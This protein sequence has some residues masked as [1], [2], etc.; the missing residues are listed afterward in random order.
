MV[1]RHP[2]ASGRGVG[3]YHEVGTVQGPQSGQRWSVV[4]MPIMLRDDEQ[5]TLI[6]ADYA[7]AEQ[8]TLRVILWP[9]CDADRTI[10]RFDLGLT[11][12]L[13]LHPDRH[14][15]PRLRAPWPDVYAAVERGLRHAFATPLTESE[16]V[17]GRERSFAFTVHERRPAVVVARSA[18]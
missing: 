6:G 14:D 4:T 12:D 2:T 16:W 10:D 18:A 3:W 7:D 17:P 9:L 1:T 13:Q 11:F 15:A 8:P 5:R